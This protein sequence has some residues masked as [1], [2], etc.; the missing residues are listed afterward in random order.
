MTVGES[1]RTRQARICCPPFARTNPTAF[2]FFECVGLVQGK[3]P[4]LGPACPL[5]PPKRPPAHPSNGAVPLGPSAPLAPSPGPAG[6]RPQQAHGPRGL[7]FK[8]SRPACPA[9]PGQ[10]GPPPLPSPT[11]IAGIGRQS[12]FHEAAQ[13]A[14]PAPPKRSPPFPAPKMVTR[15][16][17]KTDHSR[18]RICSSPG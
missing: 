14:S 6:V 10:L 3:K 2:F 5:A 9:L 15:V 12:P 18:I 16:F 7:G 11:V 4:R 17:F 1:A 13:P 8:E